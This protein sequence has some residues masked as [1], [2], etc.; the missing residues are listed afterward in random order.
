[1]LAIVIDDLNVRKNDLASLFSQLQMTTHKGE[2]LA[3]ARLLLNAIESKIA[4]SKGREVLTEFC[5]ALMHDLH[6]RFLGQEMASQ[7][8][9]A[10]G[11]CVFS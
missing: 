5:H 4:R 2:C 7:T 11:Q 6:L 9:I 8:E 10:Q 1:M 3:R